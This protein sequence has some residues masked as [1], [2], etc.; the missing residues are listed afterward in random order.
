MGVLFPFFVCCKVIE[1]WNLYPLQTGHIMRILSPLNGQRMRI[2]CPVCKGYNT[3]RKRKED[4]PGNWNSFM[5][6][7]S[8]LTMRLGRGSLW[9]FVVLA[10]CK[11]G[12]SRPK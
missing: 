9:D 8:E 10:D 7:G 3:E 5:S 4:F 11:R 2:L 1:R 6:H 12:D